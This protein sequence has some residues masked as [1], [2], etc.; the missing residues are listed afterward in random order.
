MT[1]AEQI[2]ENWGFEP[3]LEVHEAIKEGIQVG[4]N[5]LEAELDG[6]LESQIQIKQKQIDI[7]ATNLAGDLEALAKS[8]N[9]G[10]HLTNRLNFQHRMNTLQSYLTELDSLER[11]R[12][13]LRKIT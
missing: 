9:E 11:V 6:H 10:E 12:A 5:Q 8:A 3:Q 2:Q 1:P 13:H 4:R 7:Y